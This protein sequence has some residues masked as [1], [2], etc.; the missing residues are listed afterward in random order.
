[1]PWKVTHKAYIFVQM[2]PWKV[3]HKP[4]LL[5]TG[6]NAANVVQVIPPPPHMDLPPEIITYHSDLMLIEQVGCTCHTHT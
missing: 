1:M 3:T 6:L 2:M 4:Y 5:L